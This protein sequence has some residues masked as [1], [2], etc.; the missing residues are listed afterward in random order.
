M[1]FT[2]VE[3]KP[4]F[5]VTIKAHYILHIAMLSARLNPR[6]SMCYAGE[7]YM[8]HMKRIVK[9]VVNGTK[10]ADVGNRLTDR[11]LLA[12][13]YELGARERRAAGP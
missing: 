9:A 7:D 5:N 6:L 2:D 4:L 13:H 8:K 11:I 1:Y 12:L 3:P 10:A